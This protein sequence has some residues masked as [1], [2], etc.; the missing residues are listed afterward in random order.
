MKKVMM[1][2]SVSDNNLAPTMAD[3]YN[4]TSKQHT[5]YFFGDGHPF[6]ERMHQKVFDHDIALRRVRLLPVKM[7]APPPG[8]A[9]ST[10]VSVHQLL[11]EV[12]MDDPSLEYDIVDIAHHQMQ[13]LCLNDEL[14]LYL[15]EQ[16]FHVPTLDADET[17]RFLCYLA[18]HVPILWHYF[19]IF[20]P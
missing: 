18:Q 2:K 17:A 5:A 3:F 6:R 7:E 4:E 8:A 15:N 20:E 10:P 9:P 19:Q 13:T 11:L 16:C 12:T 14:S 1:I